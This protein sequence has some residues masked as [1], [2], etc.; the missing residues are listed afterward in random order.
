MW[1][2]AGP[3]TRATLC[4]ERN[5]DVACFLRRCCLVKQKASCLLVFGKT[6]S[7][8]TPQ[9][10]LISKGCYRGARVQV[11]ELNDRIN[12]ASRSPLVFACI[13]FNVPLGVLAFFGL[14]GILWSRRDLSEVGGV[15]SKSAESFSKSAESLWSSL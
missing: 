15:L 11:E 13:C 1:V 4:L 5:A 2:W 7:P 9:R 3:R 14:S 10:I 6:H 12:L 8:S